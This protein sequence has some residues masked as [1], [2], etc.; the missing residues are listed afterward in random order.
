MGTTPQAMD[1]WMDLRPIGACAVDF[2]N[3]FELITVDRKSYHQD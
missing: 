2:Y 1:H 3:L